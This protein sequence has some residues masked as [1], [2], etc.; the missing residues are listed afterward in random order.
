[1]LSHRKPRSVVAYTSQ[2]FAETTPGVSSGLTNV[3]K[4]ASAAGYTKEK[5]LGLTSEM[6]IDGKGR[7]WGLVSQR[8]NLCDSRCCIEDADTRVNQAAQKKCD[9]WNGPT[10][11]V[12]WRRAC[13]TTKGGCGKTH[14]VYSSIDRMRKFCS[15]NCL[16]LVLNGWYLRTRGTLSTVITLFG[17]AQ[18]VM[19]ANSC[20]SL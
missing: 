17:R 10:C 15:R 13:K 20:Y 12:N 9:P 8:P 3:K 4:W 2:T 7:V 19:T 14:R 18:R 6:V 1:M 11:F 16:I 5:I